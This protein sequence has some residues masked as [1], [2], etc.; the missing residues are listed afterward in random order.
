MNKSFPLPVAIAAFV[1]SLPFAE[2]ADAHP[3]ALD[4]NGGHVDRATGEYHCHRAPCSIPAKA[5]E[6]RSSPVA[7]KFNRNE[8]GGWKDT[9]NDCQDTRAEILQRDS[10]VPV[11]FTDNRSCAVIRGQWHDPYT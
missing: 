5:P 9:D 6:R 8:W 11:T 2:S 4:K 7:A 10:S 1:L 3:G